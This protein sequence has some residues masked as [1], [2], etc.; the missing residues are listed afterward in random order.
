M[1]HATGALTK[2]QYRNDSCISGY[3]GKR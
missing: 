1:M 2:T 3:T